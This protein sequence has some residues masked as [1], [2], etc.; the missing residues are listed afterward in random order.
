MRG[1]VEENVLYYL[2]QLVGEKE[3][4]TDHRPVVKDHRNI[5]DLELFGRNQGLFVLFYQEF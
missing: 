5:I 3:F 1:F 4:R 2:D